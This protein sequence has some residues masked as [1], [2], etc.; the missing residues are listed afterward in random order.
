M[1]RTES[2]SGEGQQ[3]KEQQRGGRGVIRAK[4]RSHRCRSMRGSGKARSCDP[5]E[6][7]VTLADP[8]LLAR[9]PAPGLPAGGGV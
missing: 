4:P 9:Q 7:K 3:G 1:S 2:H 6:K 8:S 5:V